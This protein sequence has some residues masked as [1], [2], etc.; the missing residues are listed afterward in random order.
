LGEIVLDTDEIFEPGD[1][2]TVVITLDGERVATVV[3]AVAIINRI[4]VEGENR[5]QLVDLGRLI[6]AVS[7]IRQE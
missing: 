7:V 6:G 4:Y 3:G 2:I 1:K 5:T